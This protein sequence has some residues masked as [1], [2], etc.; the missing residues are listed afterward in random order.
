M[1]CSYKVLEKIWVSGKIK[2]EQSLLEKT[3]DYKGSIPPFIDK[4]RVILEEKKG[5]LSSKAYGM[6]AEVL[7]ALDDEENVA[8]RYNGVSKVQ[9]LLAKSFSIDK[10]KTDI[11]LLNGKKV[12]I[13][14][15]EKDFSLIHELNQNVVS[16]PSWKIEEI[17]ERNPEE[18]EEIGIYTY[19]Y[20]RVKLLLLKGKELF[21]K[22]D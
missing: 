1:W 10:N 6:T 16:I 12:S 9:I 14:K 11:E 8:T 19:I 15:D 13:D 2:I 5:D 4:L 22:T 7:P 3:Y 21:L 18:S 17:L 20:G